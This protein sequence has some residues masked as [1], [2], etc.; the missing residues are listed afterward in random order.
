ML[1]YSIE[2]LYHFLCSECGKWFS[3]GD[4][5]VVDKLMC[6]HCGVSQKTE[7]LKTQED[8]VDAF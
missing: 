1:R 7:K 6:P 8:F 3:I 2:R 4:W 5:K